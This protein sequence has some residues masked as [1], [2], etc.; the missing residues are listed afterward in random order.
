M[1]FHVKVVFES[2]LYANTLNRIPNF[3]SLLLKINFSQI[4]YDVI[5]D[6][7]IYVESN[8]QFQNCF[9]KKVPKELPFRKKLNVEL[10]IQLVHFDVFGHTYTQIC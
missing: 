2:L 1:A 3:K 10:L 6:I 5:N 9:T 8:V 7:I 4:C